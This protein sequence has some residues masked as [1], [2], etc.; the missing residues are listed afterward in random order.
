[1]AD[2]YVYPGTQVLI[3]KE[4]IRHAEKLAMFER[5]M[6]LQRMRDGSP[7]VEMSPAGYRELHRHL[8]Q[9][10]YEWAGDLRTVALAKGSSMFCRPE[11]VEQE[12][13]KRFATI[14]A[15]G[16]LRGLTAE[17]FAG[18]AA[19][20]LSE[21]NAIHPFREGNGRTQRAFLEVL[22]QNAGH[23]VDLT[24]IDPTA[25]NEASITGFHRGDYEL[26]RQVIAGA[27]M[28]EKQARIAAN[29]ERERQFKE[30]QAER[31]DRSHHRGGR[32]SR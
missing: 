18:R 5:M 16:D 29:Q 8:F 23:P 32:S 14:H 7:T 20:H 4:D 12:L 22:G 25:W 13:Q 21:L 31:K 30:R 2:P 24:R 11:F 1:M 15:E 6:T 27:G 28:D 9:D 10:V 3:N 17:Q 19:E 26:M